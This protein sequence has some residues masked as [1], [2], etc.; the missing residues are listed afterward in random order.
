[1]ALGDVLTSGGTLAN[2]GVVQLKKLIAHPP[3]I[4][5]VGER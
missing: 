2:L 3:K 5:K 4:H 1:M